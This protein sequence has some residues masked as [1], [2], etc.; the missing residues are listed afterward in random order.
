[1]SK[2]F[3]PRST[4]GMLLIAAVLIALPFVAALGGQAWVRIVNF[5]IL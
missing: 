5:A 4:F 3:D 2:W 1:M